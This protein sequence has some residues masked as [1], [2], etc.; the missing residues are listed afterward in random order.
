MALVGDIWGARKM[1]FGDGPEAVNRRERNELCDF[2][3][4]INSGA[5]Y[6]RATGEKRN[7]FVFILLQ[8]CTRRHDTLGGALNAISDSNN[9]VVVS[10]RLER[11]LARS[12]SL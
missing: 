2:Q 9:K 4:S 7:S 12:L 3:F 10:A 6:H 11:T 8:Q 1:M 5:L